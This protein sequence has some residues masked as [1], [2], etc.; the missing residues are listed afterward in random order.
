MRNV[1]LISK[2]VMNVLCPTATAWKNILVT[3]IKNIL[4]KNNFRRERKETS[5]KWLTV[6]IFRKWQDSSGS[7][8]WHYG[9][10]LQWYLTGHRGWRYGMVWYGFVGIVCYGQG[11]GEI[12][13]MDYT[14]VIK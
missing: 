13:I 5:R 6:A 12:S 2:H 7:A 1:F 3:N 11:W 14:H 8:V 9:L 4:Y 10:K